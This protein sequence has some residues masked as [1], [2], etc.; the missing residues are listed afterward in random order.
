MAV[1]TSKGAN[2]LKTK[3][4]THDP[5]KVE[6]LKALNEL[7]LSAGYK[8]RREELKRGPGWKVVSGSCTAKGE[9][10]IFIDRHMTHD[11]QLAFLLNKVHQFGVAVPTEC[12]SRIPER[13]R[14]A[15]EA[16]AVPVAA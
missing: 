3:T 4:V 14:T 16:S 7:L 10:L 9:R 12:L 13:F 8:V 2:K 5:A 15:L 11:D 1:R 6:A